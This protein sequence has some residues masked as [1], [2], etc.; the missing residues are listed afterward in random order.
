MGA[1]RD[2]LSFVSASFSG[3]R[4]GVQVIDN[5]LQDALE[6]QQYER[7]RTKVLDKLQADIEFIREYKKLVNQLKYTGAT[8]TQIR[9]VL[10]AN[11]PQ[12]ED[13]NIDDL[14]KAE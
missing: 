7:E 13:L 9:Q 12:T 14:L 3:L 2:G 4:K 1:W 6:Q 10:Q 11:L 5:E 8:Q